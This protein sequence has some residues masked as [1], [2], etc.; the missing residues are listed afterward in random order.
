MPM[1]IM[2]S[3][4]GVRDSELAPGHFEVVMMTATGNPFAIGIDHL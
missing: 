3:T 2:A 1:I 4:V